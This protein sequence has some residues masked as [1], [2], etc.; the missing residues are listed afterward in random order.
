MDGDSH[1]PVSLILALH[2]S[3]FVSEGAVWIVLPNVGYKTW[4]VKE[5]LMIWPQQD[6]CILPL[7]ISFSSKSWALLHIVFKDS[8]NFFKK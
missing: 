6:Y 7:I 2:A 8:D 1:D 4:R 3:F 5:T